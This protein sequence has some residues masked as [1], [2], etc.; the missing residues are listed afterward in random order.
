MPF[1]A[2]FHHGVKLFWKSDL[3]PNTLIL[4]NLLNH[5]STMY[6]WAGKQQTSWVIAP[7]WF[8]VSP[9]QI[10][11]TF[12]WPRDS[13]KLPTSS[14]WLEGHLHFALIRLCLVYYLNWYLKDLKTLMPEL[15]QKNSWIRLLCCRL[16]QWYEVVDWTWIHLNN[17][18]I[19]GWIWNWFNPIGYLKTP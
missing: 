15:R 9:W 3:N 7:W 4:S 12:V 17:F 2:V 10:C 6:D 1:A 11:I 16:F 19:L 13:L 18:E 5:Y 14:S 8:S